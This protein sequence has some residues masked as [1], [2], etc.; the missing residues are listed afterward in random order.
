M[1]ATIGQVL[2]FED[3]V[4]YTGLVR[5]RSRPEAARP[6]GVGYARGRDARLVLIPIA[7]NGIAL[8]SCLFWNTLLRRG[9]QGWQAAGAKLRVCQADI[10]DARLIGE[11][12]RNWIG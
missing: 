5:R 1:P 6:N 7:V 12:L 9:R 8:I 2:A 10:R 11:P 4:L 3:G